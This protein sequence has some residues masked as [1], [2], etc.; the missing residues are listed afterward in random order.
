MEKGLTDMEIHDDLPA[1]FHCM[2]LG[3][4]YEYHEFYVTV[5]SITKVDGKD[6]PSDQYPGYEFSQ[7]RIMGNRYTDSLKYRK[8]RRK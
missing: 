2:S 6:D 7:N 1:H 4:C 3:I 8:G 5:S